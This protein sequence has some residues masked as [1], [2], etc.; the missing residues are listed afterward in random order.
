MSLTHYAPDLPSFLLSVGAG[1]SGSDGGADARTPAF[2]VDTAVVLDYGGRLAHL[3]P[4]AKAYRDLSTRADASE[5]ATAVFEALRWAEAEAAGGAKC[6]LL[7]N[8]E[9]GEAAAPAAASATRSEHA[10]ALADRLY[11]AASGRS[12]RLAA[13]GKRIV[14]ELEE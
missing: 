12:A 3:K 13:D 14:V 11:R 5:A 6:V 1:G 9:D 8:V 10:P 4:S 7:P 2:A